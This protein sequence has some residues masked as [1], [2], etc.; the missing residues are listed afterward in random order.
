MAER[1]RIGDLEIYQDLRFQEREW[2]V[3]RIGW[4]VMLLI[5]LLAL[6]GL[7]G[8]GPISTGSA[9]SDDGAIQ[10]GY[11]RFIRHD[12]RTTFTL[13]VDGS[14]ARNGEIQLWVSR[15]YLDA[16]QV[17]QITPQPADTIAAGD[18]LIYT[19][20]VDDPASAL[21]VTFS[22]RPQDMLRLS[23]DAGLV[24]GPAVSWNQLSYP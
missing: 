7:F 24:D 12:G 3:Q 5:V 17:E 21:T 14:Q 23:G 8:T 15:D 4:A 18:R 20:L 9:E 19:F 6:L 22:L 2:K 13:E 16:I 1:Q 10:A 11:E